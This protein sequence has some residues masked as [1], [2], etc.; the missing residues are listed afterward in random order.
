MSRGAKTARAFRLRTEPA[1]RSVR[2]RFARRMAPCTRAQHKHTR[3]DDDEED[4][5]CRLCLGG[6]EDGPLV[7]PCA[8]RGTATWAH[9]HCLDHWRRTSPRQD[10]AYRCGQ[11]MDEYRDALSLELLSARLQAERTRLLMAQ[12]LF[13][14]APQVPPT[15]D[16]LARELIAQGKYGEAEP[17]FREALKV[18]RGTLGNRHP[19][20]LKSMNNLATL[21]YAKKDLAAAEPLLYEALYV[22]LETLGNRHPTTLTSITNLGSLLKAKGNLVAAEQL[23][24]RALKVKR[25]TLSDRHPSTLT[26]IH[27]LGR[28]LKASGRLRAAEPLLREVLE[29]RRETLGSRHP[30]TLASVNHLGSLLKDKGD[31]VAAEPLLRE[32]LEVRRK[33][34]GSRHPA[35]LVSINSL[36][37]FLEAK[38]KLQAAESLYREAQAR[39]TLRGRQ[40]ST[41]RCA[42]KTRA[43][44]VPR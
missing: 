29:V 7:Q 38:G 4:K 30:H 25:E 13:T 2:T 41:L 6:E 5:T 40:P 12:C 14:T 16:T 33:T 31:L 17:L 28:L 39:K 43:R 35:T 18:R 3:A 42:M 36:R 9:S 44:T 1:Q 27:S 32:A 10:A 24:R 23:L 8:C 34:L 20:T 11:C 22:H 19:N 21:L 37:S 26:S 15:L